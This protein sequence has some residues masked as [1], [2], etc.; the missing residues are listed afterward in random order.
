MCDIYTYDNI[1]APLKSL[2]LFEK[3]PINPPII[4]F[5]I[6]DFIIKVIFFI[7]IQM[8]MSAISI[9]IEYTY[10]LLVGLI[11]IL[12]QLLYMIGFS[13]LHNISVVKYISFYECWSVGGTDM[14]VYMAVLSISVCVG[15]G[16]LIYI[17]T[18]F[19]HQKK[20][21]SA[22]FWQL[23]VEI[24]KVTQRLGDQKE[25]SKL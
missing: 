15:I 1:S 8:I 6:T 9:H 3:Y 23:L 13:M 14:I 16:L 5:I 17:F 18:F 7:L 22:S 21:M 25:H 2:M 20:F 24:S 4:V 10:G 11:L 19:R 12:P